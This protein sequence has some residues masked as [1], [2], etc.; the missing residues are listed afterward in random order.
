MVFSNFRTNNIKKFFNGTRA[1]KTYEWLAK[2]AVKNIAK[3]PI[4]DEA[5]RRIGKWIDSFFKSK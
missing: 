3:K 1:V 2:E 4:K 5:E